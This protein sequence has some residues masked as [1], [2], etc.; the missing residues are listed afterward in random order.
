MN[1]KLTD[2]RHSPVNF[3]IIRFA[4]VLLMLAE[5]YNECGET[6]K[7]V[8]EL[9]KVRARAGMPGIDSGP[10]WLAD[11]GQ[12]GMRE[13][14]RNERA[15]ELAGE[16]HRFSDIRRWGIAEEL[17]DG[18][19]EVEFIGTTLFTRTFKSRNNLWPV[20]SEEVTN[21]PNLLPNN[22]GW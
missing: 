11:G 15:Y 7:A 18:R 1:G 2:R 12:A 22:P 9:N 6:A 16:G 19:K 3:S 13:R 10:S 5:A 8:V 17:L 21:N 14:I 4:D 20:P